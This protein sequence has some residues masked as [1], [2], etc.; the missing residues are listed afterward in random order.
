[1]RVLVWVAVLGAG[2]VAGSGAQTPIAQSNDRFHEISQYGRVEPPSFVRDANGYLY[3]VYI[4]RFSPPQFDV[5]IARSTDGGKNW[6]LKWQAGFAANQ[7]GDFGNYEPTLA[8]DGN[9][10]LH[11]AWTHRPQQNSNGQTVQYNRFDAA[12]QKWGAEVTTGITPSRYNR[13]AALAV[14]SK[15]YVY[16]VHAHASTGRATLFKSDKPYASDMKFTAVTPAFG[17]SGSV[18]ETSM[19]I[20]AVDRV[21]VA[22]YCSNGYTVRHQCFD[23]IAWSAESMLGDGDNEADQ[24]IRLCSDLN[25]NVYAYYGHDSQAAWDKNQDPVWEIRKWD[26]ATQ[27]WGNPIP[28]YTTKRSQYRYQSQDVNY[29]WLISAT[30]DETTGEVYVIY[31]DFDHGRYVLAAWR[32]GDTSVNDFAL[33][34][35]TGSL[36]PNYPDR[37]YSPQMRGSLNPRFNRTAQGLDILF[38]VSDPLASPPT[39]TLNYDAFPVGSIQST[40]RPGIGTTYPLDLFAAG[41]AGLGYQVALTMTGT[42]GGPKIDRRWVPLTVDPLFYLTAAN[43]VPPMFPGFS[44]VLDTGGHARARMVIPAAP[45][46]VGLIL[47]GAFLTYPGGPAGMKTVSNAW[48]FQITT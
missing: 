36:A 46:L 33:L 26:G 42:A 24:G 43:R 8:V 29:P 35:T 15:D 23:G 22:Y 40:S 39:Y 5:A 19:V 48:R 21:H 10:N 16:F 2:L 37:F 31:R 27:V 25:G 4:Q 18:Y 3:F 11:C 6:N 1:M 28:V 32:D 12:T 34:G 30:C 47:H 20:D 44:G 45:V 41:D 13:N 17:A 38:T 7:T 14:D 9:G